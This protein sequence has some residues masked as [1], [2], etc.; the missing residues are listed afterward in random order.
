MWKWSSSIMVAC[1]MLTGV[2]QAARDVTSATDVVVGVPDDGDWPGGE[3]PNLAIDNNSNTKFLHYK[4]AT[5]A[6]GIRVTLRIGPVVVTGLTF[7]TANDYAVRDPIKYELSGSNTGIDGPYT[8]IASGDIQDFNGT[9]EWARYTKNTTPIEFPNTIAYAHYQLLFPAVRDP[10]S[11]NSM[12]IAE[13][14]LLGDILKAHAPSPADGTTG[15]TLALFQ[16]TKGDTG[17]LHDIYL[18][19]S[20]DLTED[21]LVVSRQSTLSSVYYHASPALEPGATYYWR[22]DQIDAAGTVYTGDVWQF[23]VASKTAFSPA[24]SNGATY[25]PTDVTLEWTAGL[26]ASAHDVYFGADSDA[27]AA[28]EATTLRATKQYTTS[29]A[30]TGLERGQTYYWRIDEVLA[31]GS[32]LTGSVWSFTVRPFIAKTDATLVGWWKLDDE[33]SDLAVDHSGY[34]NYGTRHGGIDYVDGFQGEALSFDGRNDYVTCGNDTSLTN[35]ESVSVSAWIQLGAFD[36]DRK[37]VSN[38]NNATGGYKLGVYSDNKVEFEIRDSSNVSTLN[39]S[40]EGGTILKRDTWYYVVGVYENGTAIRTYVNGV[41]DRELS[42]AS[43]PGA[44][45]GEL[46]IGREAFTSGN[47]WLGLIDDVRV[48][49]KVLTVEEISEI[50]L[51]DQSL[52]S[53]PQPASGMSLDIRSV[54]DLSWTAG[55]TAARHDVYF[56][57]DRDAVKT[58]DTSSDLY[59][60]RQTS[61][62]FAL[63]NLVEF[64]GGAYFWRI[65]EVESDG[66]TLHEGTVWRFTVPDYLI[67]DDFESYSDAEGSRIYEFWVDGYG[68]DENGSLVGYD[69][70]PFAEQEILHG[71]AQ[72]MPFRYDNTGAMYAEAEQTFDK[73]QDWTEYGVE[74]LVL[75]FYGDTTNTGSPQLYVKINGTKVAYDGAATDLQTAAWHTWPINLASTGVNVKKITTLAIGIEGSGATGILYFDDISL[76]TP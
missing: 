5:Q 35:I 17:V 26:S 59:Q 51:G 65:D 33:S 19:S 73:T 42:T 39:R 23:T 2:T 36:V 67:V 8:L 45:T 66:T 25:V 60:G 50:M 68:I 43:V 15:V 7:T 3:M 16:W 22:V 20:P 74:N 28:G 13:V 64:G 76:T 58:A 34:D 63:D 41:L 32:R 27:V 46:H 40:I 69:F 70:G 47:W 71:G 44:S 29:F 56:G 12:Q 10:S 4:G 55:D 48:Y 72:S 49:S 9:T 14:E 24:P 11:A 21:D 30:V 38:Q 75:Y 57:Q 54:E 31:G 61:T 52:A 62:G 18:G 1:A 53:D 37:I 6:T